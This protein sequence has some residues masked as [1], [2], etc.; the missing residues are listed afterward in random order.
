MI[1]RVENM[2]SPKGNKVANQ[3]IITLGDVVFFQSYNTV[4]AKKTCGNVYL[5]KNKW[6][7]SNTTGKYRNIFLGEK[8]KETEKKIKNGEY[9]L[10]DLN[11]S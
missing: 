7:C 11:R 6:D 8:K 4:I 5:D 1:A 10:A 9:I 2:V 3:F